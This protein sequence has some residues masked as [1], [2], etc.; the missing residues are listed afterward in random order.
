MQQARKTA[1]VM[2]IGLDPGWRERERE[3]CNR[4]QRERKE[5]KNGIDW[6]SSEL[7]LIGTRADLCYIY[8]FKIG[9]IRM[10]DG[11]LTIFCAQITHIVGKLSLRFSLTGAFLA[12][13]KYRPTSDENCC[14]SSSSPCCDKVKFD[15]LVHARLR[16]DPA[17]SVSQANTLTARPWWLLL[18]NWYS[19]AIYWHCCHW[20]ID[21]ISGQ[22][23]LPRC[24]PLMGFP[25]CY[26][27]WPIDELISSIDF[28]EEVEAENSLFLP[29]LL[30]Q[31]RT[32]SPRPSQFAS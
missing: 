15:T 32:R 12:A 19:E 27:H 7:I 8:S 1:D 29:L 31:T 11:E 26:R 22:S 17:S 21:S 14:S 30:Y 23:G 13:A 3:K 20:T 24:S 28:T 25:S 4:L 10:W 6:T 9:L 18:L 5:W 16:I 2:S